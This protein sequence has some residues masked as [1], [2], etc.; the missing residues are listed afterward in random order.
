MTKYY[1]VLKANPL[2]RAG[3]IGESLSHDFDKY[4]LLLYFGSVPTRLFGKRIV[5]RREVYFMKDEVE[6]VTI[7]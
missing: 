2:A 3:E 7:H 4:D 1:K 5:V 6:E